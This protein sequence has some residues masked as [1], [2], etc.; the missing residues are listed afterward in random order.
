MNKTFRILLVSLLIACNLS[1]SIAKKL[2]I[3]ECNNLLDAERC[4]A[5][6]K[7][8]SF[9]YTK[10]EFKINEKSQSVLR[11]VYFEDQSPK[12]DIFNNC[13]IF[14]GSNWEC[15][16]TE[17]LSDRIIYHEFKMLNGIFSTGSYSTFI[18]KSASGKSICGK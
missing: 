11:T 9:F 7:K 14:D 2:D 18:S 1:P 13:I 15:N 16:S 4:T 6:K 12:N 8:P 3:Y 5:C 17:R 10:W